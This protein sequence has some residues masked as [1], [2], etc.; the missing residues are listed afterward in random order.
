M[1]STTAE[2]SELKLNFQ[3]IVP[4]LEPSFV[5]YLLVLRNLAANK[6]RIK[7]SLT[8]SS[9]S[10]MLLGTRRGGVK[11][12]GGKASCEGSQSDRDFQDDFLQPNKVVIVDDI[13]AYRLFGDRIFCAPQENII[14]GI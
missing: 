12:D 10:N 3:K 1:I 8:S 2:T 9:G 7:L 13:N 5:S 14:E 6:P 11:K 4:T